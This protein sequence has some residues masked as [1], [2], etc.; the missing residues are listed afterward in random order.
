MADRAFGMGG[1]AIIFNTANIQIC[2]WA[3]SQAD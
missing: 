3:I 2:K 1:N